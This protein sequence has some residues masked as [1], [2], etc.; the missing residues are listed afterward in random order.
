MLI[1]GGG[2]VGL[3][4]AIAL[5]RFGIECLVVERHDSTSLFPKGRGLTI[6]T[7]EIFRQWGIEEQVTAAGLPREES[8]YNYFGDTLLAHDFRRVARP[9]RFPSVHSPT[10]RLVCSQDVLEPLLRRH[11]EFLGA[12]IRF[13]TQLLAF[14]Q[15]A[16]G[17]TAEIEGSD[18]ARQLFFE[19]WAIKV[20]TCGTT[21]VLL[22][23]GHLTF[24]L[25]RSE[26]VMTSSKGFL[27][28]WHRNS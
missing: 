5:R 10:N 3:C 21:F 14:E 25:P 11:A 12:D 16:D 18:S 13:S 8:L 27:H 23:F 6:R 4:A 2:P 9:D 15:D 24:A 22:H 28:F 17:V 1:V 26:I 20:P 19:V 7:L